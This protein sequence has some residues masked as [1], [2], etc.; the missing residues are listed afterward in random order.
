[1]PAVMRPIRASRSTIELAYS[2]L[3]IAIATASGQDLPVLSP[4]VAP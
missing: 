3:R 2:L 4:A 1:M